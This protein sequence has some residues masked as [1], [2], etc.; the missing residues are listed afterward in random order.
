MSRGKR[1][2]LNWAFQVLSP[3]LGTARVP[4][5]T[6]GPPVSDYICYFR[7]IKTWDISTNG[8]GL[9]VQ[10]SFMVPDQGEWG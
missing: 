4:R 5:S 1:D 10:G 7:Q 6:P 3:A 9:G 2:S 8:E